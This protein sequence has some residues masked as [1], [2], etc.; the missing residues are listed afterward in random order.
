[1]KKKMGRPP[2]RDGAKTKTMTVRLT[3]KMKFGIELTAKLY[4]ESEQE[5]VLR[6]LSELF[7]AEHGGL[8][9]DLPRTSEEDHDIP[10]FPTDILESCW[11]ERESDRFANL[12]MLM[13]SL[14]SLSEQ[15]LWSEIRGC[16]KYW[17]E[18][19]EG[20][21]SQELLRNALA[22]DWPK[23]MGIKELATKPFNGL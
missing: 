2:G 12:A 18:A 4:R 19:S 7:G 5:V 20:N 22:E 14:L 6:A 10:H 11:A 9:V 3:P 8:L 15:R 13:P 21:G 1:M 23:L 17:T 16:A